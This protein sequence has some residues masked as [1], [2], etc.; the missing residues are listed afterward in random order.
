L[1]RETF[2]LARQKIQTRIEEKRQSIYLN[3]PA[4]HSNGFLTAAPFL[5][6]IL[7]NILNRN[8]KTLTRTILTT[9]GFR[10]L[11]PFI[12]RSVSGL[13]SKTR[14]SHA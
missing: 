10:I 4:L 5:F 8:K 7:K 3:R 14:S 12:A 9:M 6:S 1:D 11:S 13:F 2:I